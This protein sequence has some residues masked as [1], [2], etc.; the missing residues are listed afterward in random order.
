MS[1]GKKLYFG[2]GLILGI[3]LALSVLNLG[4]LRAQN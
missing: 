3:V 1:I 2:F 4:G